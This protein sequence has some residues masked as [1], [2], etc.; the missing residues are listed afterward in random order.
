ME[1]EEAI[2]KVRENQKN[3]TLNQLIRY[4]ENLRKKGYDVYMKN[5]I[6]MI[7]L[8]IDN[9]YIVQK[10]RMIILQDEKGDKIFY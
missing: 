2:Q 1:K 4:M 6:G 7:E 9:V 3:M 8:I 5:R 10:P